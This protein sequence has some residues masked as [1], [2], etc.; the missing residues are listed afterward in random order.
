MIINTLIEN[1]KDHCATNMLSKLDIKVIFDRTK[2][3]TINL[4]VKN[5]YNKDNDP[6]TGRGIT[7]MALDNIFG[8]DRSYGHV[9]DPNYAE[10]QGFPV[11]V[12]P[13]ED[14]ED[15]KDSGDTDFEIT[16]ENYMFK[17]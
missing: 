6:K 8:T 2:D 12:R 10:K 17:L 9:N 14:S 11:L 1:I 4:I 16:I 3:T 15:T 7:L 13:H 5:P